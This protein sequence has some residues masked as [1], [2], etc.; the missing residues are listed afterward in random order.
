MAN[1]AGSPPQFPHDKRAFACVVEGKNIS[2]T[3]TYYPPLTL[4]DMHGVYTVDAVV[5]YVQYKFTMN[6]TVNKWTTSIV[7]VYSNGKI[8]SL[9]A[10][11]FAHPKLEQL[12]EIALTALTSYRN[13]GVTGVVQD[14][15]PIDP[16]RLPE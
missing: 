5:G 2:G 9:D 4:P 1:I 12:F 13:H 15:K 7:S 16:M 6:W 11:V 3:V 10:F 8:E 14:N